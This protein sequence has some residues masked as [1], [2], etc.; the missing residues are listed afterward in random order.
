MVIFEHL[1]FKV[2]GEAHRF[3]QIGEVIGYMYQLRGSMEAANN[4][5]SVIKWISLKD[6]T[7]EVMSQLPMILHIKKKLLHES[8]TLNFNHVCKPRV[9]VPFTF[10]KLSCKFSKYFT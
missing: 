10:V 2:A 1:F 5:M 4:K 6:P 7:S 8:R 9:I 3:I